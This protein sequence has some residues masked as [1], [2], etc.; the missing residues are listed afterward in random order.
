MGKA[1]I[2]TSLYGKTKACVVNVNYSIEESNSGSAVEFAHVMPVD[3]PVSVMS[4]LSVAN[5]ILSISCS[6]Y[7]IY[8]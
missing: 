7:S 3:L 5:P 1:F 6:T 2:V 4:S 8:F